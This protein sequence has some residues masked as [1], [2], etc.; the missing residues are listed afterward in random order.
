MSSIDLGATGVRRAS[1][2]VKEVGRHRIRTA[3]RN[4][5]IQSPWAGVLIDPLRA[6][7]PLT[8]IAAARLAVGDRAV[9][10]GPSAA[11]LHGL[12]A[13]P[14]TPVH[15]VLPYEVRKQHRAGIVVHNGTMLE[16]DQEERQGLPTL[17]LERVVSDLACA[18]PPWQALAVLDEALA[19]HD[20]SQ[21]PAFQRRL[22]ERL[23]D[24]PDPRGT[25][26][27]RRLVDLATG[28]AESIPE[29][30]L[31]WKVADLGFPVPEVNP[32]IF[33][34]DGVRLY[35]VDL[36]WRELRIAVEYNGYAA[37]TG[38]E[39]LDAARISDLERRGWI[40]VV[41]DADELFGTA[42]LERELQEA[43]ARRGVDLRG[44]ITGVLRPRPHRG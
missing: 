15:L 42:R 33:G 18:P 23:Q 34:I 7:D 28:R 31:L 20:E 35:R 29:S 14:P 19:R 13:V 10:T 3:L 41:I 16:D 2:V 37:H 24:R 40:V 9:V 21:R 39:E 8:I 38:R 32:W 12:T 4:G 36:G 27:G 44:R 5:E 6:A 25:R 26:I 43:F 11:Y 22:R 30:W 17:S 1:D